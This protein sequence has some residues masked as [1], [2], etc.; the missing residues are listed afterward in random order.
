MKFD[1]PYFKSKTDTDCGPLAL[2]MVMA[3]LGKNIS[4]E[5]ISKEEKQLKSGMVWASGIARASKI[6]GFN[7][8]IIST[9]NF[10][11][12]DDDINYYNQHT[13][14]KGKKIL[15]ELNKE[16][17]KLGVEIIE[18]DISL[19][20]LLSYLTK[21]SI[22]IVLVNWFVLAGIEGYSGHFLPVTGYDSENIYVHNPGIASA[23]AYLPLKR[24]LF[25][26]AWESKGT[27]KEVIMVS[28][29]KA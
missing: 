9:S 10:D 24:E 21:D 7:T 4:V 12:E 14:E 1:V 22:P 11:L 13:D 18:K 27:D 28:R 6:F 3:Y 26:K 29:P 2:K 8:K 25:L 19:E 23:K 16:I 17:K 15:R 5:E 20:E